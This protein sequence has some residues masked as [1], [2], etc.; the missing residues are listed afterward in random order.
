[1]NRITVLDGY[2]LNPGDLSWDA[3][4]SLG[5]TTIHD[6]TAPAETAARIADAE[7]V[8]TNKVPLDAAL[9]GAAPRL[10]YIGVMATGYNI[11]DLE[12][13]AARGITV[14][15]VP[16][17]STSSVAQLTMALILEL[18]NHTAE[19][20]ERVRRGDWSS[21]PDFCL[22]G[23]PITELQ[24]KTL[25]IIGL[26]RIGQALARIALAMGMRVIA[27]RRHEGDHMDGV[28]FV[29]L[30]QCFR[31]ADVLSLHCPLQ[32]DNRGFV[33]RERLG[34]MKPTALLINTSRGPL[35][36]ED[37]LAEALAA[38]VIAGAAVDVLSSEPPSPDNPLLSAP[39]CLVTPHIGWATLDARRRLMDTV[40]D[41]LRAFLEGRPVHVVAP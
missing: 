40:V 17:Y 36:R 24:D 37:D 22:I 31:E 4:N 33:N 29:D 14:T 2:T 27:A 11:I 13:A 7:I 20:A 6:R 28:R 41:N 9:M 8:L 15:N 32:E 16:S 26:G 1:M 18:S 5:A 21:S 3:L 30:D 19:Y 39:R 12:A 38:G 23:R 25:A 34:T 35:I 10:R